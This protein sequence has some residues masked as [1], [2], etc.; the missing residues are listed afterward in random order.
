M[1]DR[2]QKPP[3]AQRR[4]RSIWGELVYVCKKIH[5]WLYIRKDKTSAH[6]FLS[7]LKRILEQLPENDMAIVRAE[8]LALFHELQGDRNTAIKYRQREIELI[9]QLHKIAEAPGCRESTRAFM[10]A[11][12]DSAALQERQEIIRALEEDEESTRVHQSKEGKGGEAKGTRLLRRQR[13]GRQ[14]GRTS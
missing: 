14:R 10:L 9:Q 5:Y 3:R 6:R 7:R 12:R 1:I 8:G 2:E 4:F 13:E 11:G